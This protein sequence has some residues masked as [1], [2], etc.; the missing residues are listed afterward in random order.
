[1]WTKRF[2]LSLVERA[3]KTFVQALIAIWPLG[4]AA[5][6]LFDVDWRK[7]VSV[8]GMAALV[9][10][11]TSILSSPVGPDGSPS[12][13]GE[14]PKE[15]AAVLNSEDAGQSPA[16]RHN[17]VLGDDDPADIPVS[18]FTEPKATRYDGDGRR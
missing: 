18:R 3:I 7:S 6:G 8:A 1:M 2:W 5:L 4:D 17:H 9:S 12:L 11:A 13:V 14:P 15:P 10:V 16:E